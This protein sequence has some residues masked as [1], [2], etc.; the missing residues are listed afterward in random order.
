MWI[1][2]FSCYTHIQSHSQTLVQSGCRTLLTIVKSSIHIGL[3][4][5]ETVVKL[6][7]LVIFYVDTED[8]DSHP[9]KAHLLGIEK[10][11]DQVET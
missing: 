9:A 3:L 1:C 8:N 2:Y 5:E 4:D 6:R 11:L 10:I 7:N